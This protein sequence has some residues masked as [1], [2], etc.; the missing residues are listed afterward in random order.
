MRTGVPSF[1]DVAAAAATLHGA[2]HRTPVLTSTR[3]NAALG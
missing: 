3:I 2:A 1:A